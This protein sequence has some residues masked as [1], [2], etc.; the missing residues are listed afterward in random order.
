MRIKCLLAVVAAALIGFA[1]EAW[2]FVI[3]LEGDMMTWE[4]AAAPP[5]GT[6]GVYTL[7][8]AAQA[9]YLTSG[10]HPVLVILVEFKDQGPLG[11]T[12]ADWAQTFFGG[13]G[14]VQD[15]YREVSYGKLAM[16]QAVEGFGTV[17][18]G[19]IGWLPLG[20]NH[21]NTGSST[22]DANRKLAKD[23][24]IAADPYVDYSAYDSDGNGAIDSKELSIVIIAAGYERSY[25][26]SNA[27]SV[28]GHRWSLSLSVP[29]PVLDGV[30]V[31]DSFSNGGYMQYGEWHQRN[32][33]DGH[34]ATIGI[35]VHEMGHDLGLPDLYDVDGGSEGI[36]KWG[37][38]GSG[39]WCAAEGWPGSSPSHLCAWSKELLGFL[40][41]VTVTNV[42]SLALPDVATHPTVYRVNTIDP[43]QYFLIENRQP[44]GYDRGLPMS[45]GGIL[46]W[47]IDNSVGSL[48]VNNVNADESRK[49][50]DLEEAE[51]GAAGVSELDDELNRGDQ[52]DL[53]Y[54]GNNTLFDD[55][56][57]PEA[58]LY[59]YVYSGVQISNI[60]ASGNPMTMDISYTEPVDGDG[61]GY[62][63][64]AD[65]DDT[66]RGVYPDAPG[67]VPG[68]GIDTNC[69]GSDDCFVAMASFGTAMEGKIEV[70]RRFRD[71]YLMKTGPGRAFVDVYYQKGPH[72]ADALLPH[73]LLKRMVRILLLPIVGFASLLV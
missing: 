41:P 8:T 71:L 49:R 1:T 59:S 20:Y 50:V 5:A 13:A 35:M 29:P 11:T 40:T 26:S 28:W 70:L 69:N 42:T 7:F 56:T 24:L 12:E 45:S 15:Y 17:D 36:G 27:P 37:L 23:A 10:E 9:R 55:A 2:S 4:G 30:K 57:S 34:M 48:F 22:G 19:V 31:A 66:R 52:Q 64:P 14:S 6:V 68:D 43:N 3:G 39:S 72:L 16:T 73:P 63:P 54:R 51:E 18:N 21:P 46:I 47:H 44:V 60:S 53:Y 32:H 61:D 65:C 25:S 62:Y 67:E 38:M 33:T 58:F